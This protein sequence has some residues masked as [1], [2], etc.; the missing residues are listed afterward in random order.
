[1][2]MR[3]PFGFCPCGRGATCD[4]AYDCTALVSANRNKAPDAKR[5]ILTVVA[6]VLSG[7]PVPVQFPIAT[8]RH[9]AVEH[10]KSICRATR[11]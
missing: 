6:E 9:L 4:H 1:M 7:N 2:Y 10:I 8:S 3:I 11:L 5:R